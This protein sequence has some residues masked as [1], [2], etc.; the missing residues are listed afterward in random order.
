MPHDFL[1]CVPNHHAG[2]VHL[3]YTW[4]HPEPLARAANVLLAKAIGDMTMHSK[5]ALRPKLTA[6]SCG[7]YSFPL[8]L[9]TGRWQGAVLLA[10]RCNEWAE[11]FPETIPCSLK[12]AIGTD[13]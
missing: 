2:L 5:M 4:T 10:V 13:R 8:A 9:Q 1:S 11:N 6:L 3:K 12:D 7:K